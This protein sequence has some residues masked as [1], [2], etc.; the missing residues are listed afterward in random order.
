MGDVAMFLLSWLQSY[1][2]MVRFGMLRLGRTF[3]LSCDC[4]GFKLL[5][6]SK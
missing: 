5:N 4:W 1:V 3:C 2:W 6:D